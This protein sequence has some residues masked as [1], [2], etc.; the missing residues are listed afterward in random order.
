MKN[1]ISQFMMMMMM[2]FCTLAPLSSEMATAQEFYRRY[3]PADTSGVNYG[4]C[5]IKYNDE[6]ITAGDYFAQNSGSAQIV[7]LY[8]SGNIKVHKALNGECLEDNRH[9]T[10]KNI[11]K[12]YVGG[13]YSIVSPYIPPYFGFPAVG[14]V[15]NQ[16]D[17]NPTITL[18]PTAFVSIINPTTLQS[19]WS[20]EIQNDSNEI[21]YGV[22]VLR[23]RLDADHFLAM[24]S[25]RQK[26]SSNVEQHMPADNASVGFTS[27]K[28]QSS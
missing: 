18:K 22:Q 13:S 8:L 9:R 23:D 21:S 11:E 16:T 15:L 12:E 3:A 1:S 27:Q 5:I 28:R 10:L 2:T 6:F 7:Q 19:I 24:Q 4:N 17:P 26:Q 20:I 14:F 25:Y